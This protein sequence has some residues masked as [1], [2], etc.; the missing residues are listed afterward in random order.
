MFQKPYFSLFITRFLHKIYTGL[1]KSSDY[2]LFIFFSAASL[3]F[4]PHLVSAKAQFLLIVPLVCCHFY[5]SALLY[6]P[7][8]LISLIRLFSLG[9]L[10]PQLFLQGQE[11]SLHISTHYCLH[12]DNIM[13]QIRNHCVE[14][15][16]LTKGKPVSSPGLSKHFRSL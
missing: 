13:G 15:D 2:V 14:W 9:W 1:L 11:R 16:K 3:M 6:L 8:L 5:F 12:L 4:P 7:Q 10:W